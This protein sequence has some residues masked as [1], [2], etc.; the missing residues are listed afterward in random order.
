MTKIYLVISWII[1]LFFPRNKNIWVY[2]EGPLNPMLP[3]VHYGNKSSGIK[4][5]YITPYK[6]RIPKLKANGEKRFH[7]RARFRG[8]DVL[9]VTIA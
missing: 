6:E 9:P 8:L 2:A 3:L 5:I 4:H 1:S 7:G